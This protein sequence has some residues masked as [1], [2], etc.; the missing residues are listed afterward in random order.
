MA[1]TTNNI[2]DML[3]NVIELLKIDDDEKIDLAIDILTLIN[4]HIG[5]ENV[6]GSIGDGL[7]NVMTFISEFVTGEN[8][9][10][11]AAERA[12]KLAITRHELD[13]LFDKMAAVEDLT[14]I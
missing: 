4:N 13:V 8:P 2:V 14:A 1:S 12:E 9:D 5:V 7:E 3:R 6:M 10:L 11:S